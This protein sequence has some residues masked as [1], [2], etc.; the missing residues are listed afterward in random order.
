MKNLKSAIKEFEE[1]LSSCTENYKQE[2]SFLCENFLKLNRSEL[3]IKE[4]I[5]D[6]EYK[7][8]KKERK[9]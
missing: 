7:Q 9:E 8:I 1:I 3:I 6:K 5:S 2:V 4:F